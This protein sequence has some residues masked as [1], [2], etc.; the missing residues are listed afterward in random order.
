MEKR[1]GETRHDLAAKDSTG[2]IS[3][4]SRLAD[5]LPESGIVCCYVRVSLPH[6]PRRVR[7]GMSLASAIP[8]LGRSN[9]K[10]RGERGQ[11]VYEQI[12]IVVCRQRRAC[13]SRDGGMRAR[14]GRSQTA[15]Q[16]A[17]SLSATSSSSRPP[18][19]VSTCIAIPAMTASHPRDW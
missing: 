10:I 13:A 18:Q 4:G 8:R 2:T 12:Q 19:P 1:H 9:G 16:Y 5:A 15:R 14:G 7:L 3:S 17:H 11:D 6:G